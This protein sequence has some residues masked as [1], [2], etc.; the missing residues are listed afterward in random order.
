MP[1]RF[2]EL[3]GTEMFVSGGFIAGIRPG[4]GE[5]FVK[6]GKGQNKLSL[7]VRHLAWRERFPL[8]YFISS[9]VTFWQ[10]LERD[11]F[12]V[13]GNFVSLTECGRSNID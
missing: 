13:W 7:L 11:S 6:S 10:N 9:F 5:P 12:R 4:S 2:V 1:F 3:F 8:N